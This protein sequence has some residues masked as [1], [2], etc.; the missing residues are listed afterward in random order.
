MAAAALAIPTL[1]ASKR[2]AFKGMLAKLERIEQIWSP[3]VG[4]GLLTS[5]RSVWKIDRVMQ[6]AGA[7]L[8]SYR[9]ADT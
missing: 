9:G 3:Q 8:H 2:A 5:G 4:E 7:M 1:L 6:H